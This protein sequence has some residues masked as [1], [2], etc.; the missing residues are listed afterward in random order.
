MRG[1]KP[2]YW[3]FNVQAHKLYWLHHKQWQGRQFIGLI[4]GKEKP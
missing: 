3:R 1:T 4:I 2:L